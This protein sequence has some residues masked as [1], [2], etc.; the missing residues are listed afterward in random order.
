VFVCV[1]TTV[2]VEMLDGS[3]V[4]IV[5]ALLL[6]RWYTVVALLLH[7]GYTIVTLLLHCC[8]TLVTAVVVQVFDRSIAGHPCV[9]KS[10]LKFKNSVITV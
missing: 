2:V 1:C 4:Y 3:I 9:L 8:Y 5:V 6:H 7:C 10:R